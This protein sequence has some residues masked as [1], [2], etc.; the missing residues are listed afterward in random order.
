MQW[1]EVQ[2]GTNNETKERRGGIIV[3]QR[4]KGPS[5]IIKWVIY[6]KN[7]QTIKFTMLILI[8]FHLH[9]MYWR[10]ETVP[11]FLGNGIE[12]IQA[13]GFKGANLNMV[14]YWVVEVEISGYWDEGKLEYG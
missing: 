7:G 3:G 5:R 13:D 11:Y 8:V 9:N 1:I 14:N 12:K 2:S 4:R 10:T 6:Q